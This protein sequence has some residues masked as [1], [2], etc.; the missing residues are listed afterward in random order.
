MPF[1]IDQEMMSGKSFQRNGA[2]VNP[3]LQMNVPG[4]RQLTGSIP[5]IPI[6]HHE[7]PRAVY[8]HPNKP[9][10]EIEH[11]NDKFEVV[12]TEVV[13]TEHLSKS[14]SCSEHVNGG[15]K[16]C[17]GCQKALD[18][19]LSEGWELKP[20]LPAK[21]KSA[22]EDLYGKKKGKTVQAD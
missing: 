10:R 16:T 13:P 18:L 7:F 5:V 20:Y 4:E 2:E 6:P 14:V 1:A 8:M 15:P 11:R 17:E 22:T 19:A 9:F 12:G 3:P 21:P